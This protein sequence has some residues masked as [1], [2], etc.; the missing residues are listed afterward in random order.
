MYKRHLNQP[1]LL[2]EA[3][4]FGGIPLNP[5]NDWVRLTKMIPWDIIEDE[6]NKKL[7]PNNGQTACTGRMAFGALLIKERYGFSD[8]D[9]VAEITMNPY[10]Q[11]FIGLV[12]FQYKTPFDAS[13]M[14]RFRQRFTPEFLQ[15]MNDLI[16]GRPVIEENTSDSD[17][18]DNS[19][20][21]GDGGTSNGDTGGGDSAAETQS[22]DAAVVSESNEGTLILDATCA[23]QA[24][25]YPTDVSLLNEAR[26]TTEEVIDVL[27]QYDLTGTEKKPRTYRKEA[28]NKYNS[29]S[30]SRKKSK[31][32]IRKAIR[33]QLQYLRRNLGII[34]E[35][36]REHPDG[37]RIALG[38][39]LIERMATVQTV[40]EQQKEM[41]DEKKHTID[42]RI[43]SLSQPW[44][45]PIVRGKQR[46][47]VEFG[48][49]VEMSVVEGYLRIEDLRWDAYNESTTLQ[50]SVKSYQ[51]A[52]GHYPARV[53]ADTIFR[54]RENLR[55]CKKLGIHMN[56]P[57]LGRRAKDDGKAYKE[58]LKQE[59]LESGERGEIER[60]FGVAK[61]RY[62]LA[63]IVTKL[64]DS[65]EA[66]IHI[67]VMTMNLWKKLRLLLRFFLRRRNYV[68][69]VPFRGE[70]FLRT[71]FCS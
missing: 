43:V 36:A 53:L 55:F 32:Q 40:F 67:A 38:T 2:D 7:C 16:I 15:K 60:Q 39:K 46:A 31:K 28:R 49:K 3:E 62:S 37:Y 71:H 11:Y 10:L 22:A 41:Y 33:E 48:A 5:E 64:K 58:A 61:R 9:T 23:P 68:M 54:T 27:H 52:Y 20:K 34:K 56:G 14:T 26:L 66:A 70:F 57:K 50:D 25:R 44:I 47:E 51:K 4:N 17:E 30:K 1:S 29:F 19:N 12:T 24:I 63:A 42:N 18:S 69:F 13:M 6:Y 8:V 65:S 35:I 45:R 59:W 21:P